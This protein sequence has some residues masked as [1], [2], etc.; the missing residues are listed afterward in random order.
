MLKTSLL[1]TLT[2]LFSACGGGGTSIEPTPL[3]TLYFI[4]SPVNGID[5]HCGVRNGI[6]KHDTI[7]GKDKNGV[8]YCSKGTITFSL[9]SLVLGSIE[10]YK[11][12]QE[13]RPQD[14]LKVPQDS[15]ENIEL[16]KMAQLIQSLDD[17]GEIEHSINI[18]ETA[19]AKLTDKSLDG[20]SLTEVDNLIVNIGK[21][22]KELNEV[23]KHL[24]RNSSISYEDAKPTVAPFSE[25]IA[26]A[27]SAGFTIGKLSINTGKAPITSLMLSGKGVE[28]FQLNEDGT[29]LLLK[30]FEEAK[31]FHLEVQAENIYGIDKKPV[32]ITIIK[33]DK[34]ARV[35]LGMI[36]EATVKIIELTPAFPGYKEKLIFTEQLSKNS[37]FNIHAEE[38]YDGTLYIFEV[39]KGEIQDS[40][41]DGIK[42][43]EGSKPYQ[44]VLRLIAWG[45]AIKNS[46]K[47]IYISPLS[48][49]L[50]DYSVNSFK[51]IS[52]QNYG[53]LSTIEQL[54]SS[55]KILL[56]KDLNKDSIINENDILFFN[57]LVD[58][59][60]LYKTLT[61]KQTYEKI[62]QKL[63]NGDIS[64]LRNLFQ[65]PIL[66]SFDANSTIKVDGSFAYVYDNNEF[67]IYDLAN[68]KR[69]GSL[70]LQ[71]NNQEEI[72]QLESINYIYKDKFSDVS[73]YLNINNNRI[74]LSNLNSSVIT[75]DI[76]NLNQPKILMQEHIG[77]GKKIIGVYN[78][79]IFFTE[80]V[81]NKYRDIV[82]T[83]NIH[84]LNIQNIMAPTPL[85]VKEL[86][87]IDYIYKEGENLFGV[88]LS[89]EHSGSYE[90]NST[91]RLKQYQ[92]TN[93]VQSNKAILLSNQALDIST[94]IVEREHQSYFDKNNI[95]IMCN[96]GHTLNLYSYSPRSFIYKDSFN[97]YER[98]EGVIY[99]RYKDTLYLSGVEYRINILSFLDLSSD[100]MRREDNAR[101]KFY[102]S[103]PFYIDENKRNIYFYQK[104][105]TTNR[106]IIDT[107]SYLSSVNNYFFIYPYKDNA[108]TESWIMDIFLPFKEN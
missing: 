26:T 31:T 18:D 35:E 52:S 47:K 57:P 92:L 22:P 49:M 29:L 100:F 50:Y 106:Y 33:G 71:K 79:I 5:Y 67:Y 94:Y 69:L 107:Q 63:I 64:Y 70:K 61:N 6:T 80:G 85:E 43:I 55:S 65:A 36:R 4:D 28:N 59:S 103:R 66:E 62:T 54:K 23:K 11:D 27:S 3:K 21:T 7:E 51:E 12:K 87:Y 30:K 24:I 2:L 38:L 1:L 98:G 8:L 13:I 99:N 15:F 77:L 73:I 75:I 86:P 82:T 108:L 89:F 20:L 90:K 60:S 32:E 101:I 74:F 16:L 88:S 83:T 19:K 78:N 76:Q 104:F 40:N 58:K 53:S 102:N 42:D 84:I 96:D 9:G 34:L 105:F 68:Q 10:Q 37:N 48:E 97:P 14:L 72:K 45:A 81:P 39:T 17:D 56:S 93:L 95:Y 44:G 46:H 91:L 41:N 25:D